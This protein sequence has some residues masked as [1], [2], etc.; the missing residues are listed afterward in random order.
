MKELN[1]TQ[2]INN[3]QVYILGFETNLPTKKIK[4]ELKVEFYI[5]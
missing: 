5:F 4:V 2:R 1:D 3:I